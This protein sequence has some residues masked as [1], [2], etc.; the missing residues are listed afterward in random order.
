M[1]KLTVAALAVANGFVCAVPAYAQDTKIA[2]SSV[3]AAP[4]VP[5]PDAAGVAAPIL[6]AAAPLPIDDP[7]T[8]SPSPRPTS[9]SPIKWDV[10]YIGEVAANP[11]GG[12]KQKTAYSGQVYVGADVDLDAL[13]GIKG[14]TIHGALTNRHGESLS[15][16]AIGNG[17]SVQEIHGLQNT[18]LARLTYEQKLFNDRLDLEVGR[19]VGAVNTLASPLYCNF[20]S[21]AVCGNPVVIYKNSN[22]NGFPVS[23]WGLKAQA[24]LTDKVNILTGVY[25][26]NPD[27]NRLDNDGFNFSFHGATGAYIPIELSYSTT[28]ANDRLP[29]NYS[30]GIWFDRTP[31]R[32]PVLDANGNAAVVSGLPYERRFGRS[33]AWVRFDQMISRP[34]P[35]SKRGLSVFGIAL[36]SVSGRATQSGYLTLGLLQ[37]GTFRGRDQDTI[38]F[39]VT[40]QIFSRAAV[41][42][43]Q[44]ARLSVGGTDDVPRNEFMFELNYGLQ[45]GP[46]RFMPYLQY[47]VHPDQQ[48][49]PFRTKDI[50]DA[51]VVGAKI[52]INLLGALDSLRRR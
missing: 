19:M 25:E 44:A 52:S 6:P 20:Q 14:G 3:S 31:Y 17:T 42:N 22:I 35:N 49:E 33:S 34:D 37:T 28:F 15:D 7:R 45:L 41:Q 21:N 51:F 2:L 47:I 38:G 27:Q 8:K 26:M 36:T 18:H 9:S 16:I 23:A 48:A 50:P 4:V 32:D 40:D 10:N 11:S 30:I 1:K 24:W 46:V 39:A 13:F 43:I 29:R 5:A 12:L